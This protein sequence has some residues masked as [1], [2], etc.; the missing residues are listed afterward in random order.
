MESWSGFSLLEQ[1]ALGSCP[2]LGRGG[3]SNLNSQPLR[4]FLVLYA[5]ILDGLFLL[6]FLE[7]FG[8]AIA[9]DNI[10]TESACR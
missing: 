8:E 1:R 2:P 10:S 9:L 3:C 7:E 6:D 5:E 4:E